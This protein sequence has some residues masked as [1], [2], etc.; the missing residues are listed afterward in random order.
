MFCIVVYLVLFIVADRDI[1]TFL[2]YVIYQLH[3]YCCCYYRSCNQ[4]K[5]SNAKI[6]LIYI[7][8][9]NEHTET[10]KTKSDNHR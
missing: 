6:C 7:Y 8:I 4:S 10:L 3:D 2:S 5:K 1:S 9:W